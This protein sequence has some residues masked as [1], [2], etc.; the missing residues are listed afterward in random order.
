[1]PIQ[2][3]PPHVAAQIA[4]GEVVERPASVVKELVEN[5]LDAGA[6]RIAISVREGGVAEIRITD[7]GCGIPAD[8]LELAFRHH[9]TSKLST[10][11]DL[12]TVA[13]L[14]FRGE[15]LPSVAAVARIS[16]TTRTTHAEAGARIEF[17]YGDL[18]GQQAAGCPVGTT[19][20]AV[21][22]FGNLP[23]RRRFLRSA[24]AET[25][26]VQEVITRYALAYPGV[27]FTLTADG[28]EQ[29]NTPGSG[30]LQD[31]IRSLYGG[32]VAARM[33]PVCADDG[34]IAVSGYA[35]APDLN[36]HNRSNITLLVNRR[37][38]YHRSVIYAIEQAYQ[39]TLPDRR[40]PLAVI[41]VELPAAEVDVNSHPT[42]RE[43]RFRNENR[44]FS[45]V[46]RAVHDALVAHAPVREAAR[47]FTPL[48][49]PSSDAQPAWPAPAHPEPAGNAPGP[50]TNTLALPTTGLAPL[51][52]SLR[53]VIAGLRVV[54]QIH[55]TYVV[56]EGSDGMYLVD[57]HA[58]HERIVYD[59]I[60]A[61][62]H[63]RVAQPLLAPVSAE[64]TTA[65]T[66][67][68]EEYSELLSGYGF[69]LEPFGGE[70]WLVRAVPATLAAGRNPDPAQALI[71]LLD[72]VAVEQ[73]VMEREDALAATIAC[74][75]AV[76][77]GHTLSHQEMDALL[78]QL[79]T[80]DNPHNC[81][82]GRPTVI[83]FTEYQLERE[84]G[85][86]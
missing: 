28:R 68:I 2:Q 52:G 49:T 15:A 71:N 45:A 46:Q 80:T 5:S 26:R 82:H 51:T 6:T 73:V 11:A 41:N 65:Q 31:V 16:C 50:A 62:Q 63:E 85:R 78:R 81:P 1:M 67:T 69:Q 55:Q 72:A 44:I 54:G 4:A 19:I 8:E 86:R 7:D 57:Q 18:L 27:R 3:L 21:E 33:L 75:G 14:G 17:R 66:A 29:V 25:A 77:A 37:W 53:D 22:L 9:A 34:N 40:Y 58:A 30:H 43:V 84:F 79:E 76:R 12:E 60:R 39:R 24:A 61:R 35:S 70:A 74:H 42:K 38:V 47:S 48:V 10:A 36:R 32:D 59:R 83:H 56:A 13:T 64:L 20:E 23:A